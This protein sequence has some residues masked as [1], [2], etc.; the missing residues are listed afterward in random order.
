MKKDL[1]RP[2]LSIP[3]SDKVVVKW[4]EKQNSMSASV[5]LLIRQAVGQYGYSDL[6][7]KIELGNKQTVTEPVLEVT[8]KD[9]VYE[10]SVTNHVNIENKTDGVTN[11][12][13]I[14]RKQSPTVHEQTTQQK[15]RTEKMET[16]DVISA[17]NSML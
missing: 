3:L 12:D 17:I 13:F 4:L 9:A 7:S 14:G 8:E 6:L 15:V 11:C 16:D 5:R 1:I 10:Q 2:R